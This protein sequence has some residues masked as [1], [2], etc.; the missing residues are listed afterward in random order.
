MDQI[1]LLRL[2]EGNASHPLDATAARWAREAA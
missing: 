2:A 1:T